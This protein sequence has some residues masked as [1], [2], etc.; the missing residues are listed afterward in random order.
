M[1]L[2]FD[3]NSYLNFDLN[4]D[5]NLN[6]NFDWNL[7]LNFDLKWLS[8]EQS[9]SRLP[10]RGSFDLWSGIRSSGDFTDGAE[11]RKVFSQNYFKLHLSILTNLF[12]QIAKCICPSYKTYLSKGRDTFLLDSIETPHFTDRSGNKNHFPQI[13]SM[14]QFCLTRLNWIPRSIHLYTFLSNLVWICRQTF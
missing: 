3:W 7:Y 5:L 4:F 13:F 14:F 6:L 12:V 1:Y 9:T 2:N 8:S 10:T 11:Y